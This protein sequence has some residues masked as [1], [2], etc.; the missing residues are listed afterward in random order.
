MRLRYLILLLLGVIQF[1]ASYFSV[2][3][4]LFSIVN[5]IFQIPAIFVFLALRV[6][7]SIYKI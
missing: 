1:C 6:R 4:Y 3:K 2:A 7:W 5:Q